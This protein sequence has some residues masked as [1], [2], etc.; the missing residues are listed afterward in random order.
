MAQAQV[1]VMKG[2]KKYK[3]PTDLDLKCLTNLYLDQRML[4]EEHQLQV[5]IEE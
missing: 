1:L 5:S 2:A 4:I 3:I